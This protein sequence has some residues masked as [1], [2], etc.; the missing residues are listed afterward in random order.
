MPLPDHLD[1]QGQG[2]SWRPASIS[3]RSLRLI[4]LPTS[5]SHSVGLIT[6]HPIRLTHTHMR[7]E[8]WIGRV[9]QQ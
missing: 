8:G 1:C 6:N 9:H 4:R 5:V 3:E 7:L 2:A